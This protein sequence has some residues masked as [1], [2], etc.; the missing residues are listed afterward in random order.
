MVWS[1]VAVTFRP[2]AH[3][4]TEGFPEIGAVTSHVSR[5]WCC[6]GPY[7]TMNCD[8]TPSICV[9]RQLESSWPL[10]L[11][12]SPSLVSHSRLWF[13]R[14]LPESHPELLGCYQTPVSRQKPH[15]EGTNDTECRR[16]PSDLIKWSFIV[17]VSVWCFT[18]T[19]FTCVFTFIL[20]IKPDTR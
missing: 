12:S 6:S 7:M 16:V 19:N 2:T 8:F 1:L 11:W 10:P 17:I 3:L 13:H 18:M 5:S 9:P 20:I 4:H 15:S 14:L